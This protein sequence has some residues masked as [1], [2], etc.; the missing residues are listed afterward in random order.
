M[1]NSGNTTTRPTPPAYRVEVYPGDH[2]SVEEC[3]HVRIN[4]FHHE[5]GFPLDTEIDELESSSYHILLRLDEG[6]KPVG[7]IRGTYKPSISPNTYK[8][9]RLAILQ[10]YR[11][12]GW[13]GVLVNAFHDWVKEDAQKRGIRD[14]VVALH[15]QIPVKPFYAKYEYEPEGPEFDEEGAPHQKMVRRL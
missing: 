13:G 1:S 10:D 3:Y 11:K 4:V 12:Y 6:G 2:K 7:T 14:P 5:Q 15:S 9:S 8:L